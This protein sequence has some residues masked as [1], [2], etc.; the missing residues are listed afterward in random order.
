MFLKTFLSFC[1][2]WGFVTYLMYSAKQ[3]F[4]SCEEKQK[5]FF[6]SVAVGAV[7]A[8]IA[9]VVLFFFVQIF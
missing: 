5:Y 9:S 2:L 1:F 8:T 4:N 7:S 6:K 3:L